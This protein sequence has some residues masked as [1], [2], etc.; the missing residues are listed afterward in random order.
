MPHV[1]LYVSDKF[2]GKSKRG[3]FGDVIMEI[4]WSV[5]QVMKALDEAGV[6]ENTWVIFTSDN[7]PWLSYGEHAG[8]AG[9]LREGKGTSWEGGLRV[10][11]LMRW[12]GQIPE[13][14]T[15]ERP[16]MTIDILPTLAGRIGAEL[17]KHP[18]D[19]KDVWPLL[20]GD[21]DAKSP[22]EHYF[23]WYENNQLQAVISADGQWKLQLPHQY[24]S[25]VG[26]ARA[27]GGLP[28]NYNSV[29]V[30]QPELYHM[31][32]EVAESSDVAK[33]YPG[34]VKQLLAAAED[35]REMLGD[36]LQDRQGANDQVRDRS[37]PPTKKRKAKK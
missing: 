28:V 23:I 3:V 34:T 37:G 26:Q 17:P 5:G 9:P 11:C 25:I 29:S 27:T 19:G 10:P 32:Q 2:K 15:N 36:S 24:R 35:A 22:H 1:P 16:L 31:S 8:S 30:A 20:T 4:D 14:A 18:I 12:P 6:A 21:A 7:G 33:E 13:A